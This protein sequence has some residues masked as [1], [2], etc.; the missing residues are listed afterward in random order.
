MPTTSR[1][2]DVRL[3][4]SLNITPEGSLVDL[5]AAV[6]HTAEDRE[7]KNQ[8]SKERPQ[9]TPSET[10]NVGISDMHLKI[11]PESSIREAPRRI[12]R[13]REASREEALA[14]TQQFFAAVD[15]RNR[16][17]ST[18]RSIG[19][20]PEVCGREDIDVPGTSTSVVTTTLVIPDVDPVDTSSPRVILPSGSPS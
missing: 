17:D 7:R 14:S 1:H 11:K 4:P 6:G 19:V 5:L 20:S 12:Q 13:T 15:E 2:E 18:G 8:L 10:A 3:D 16:N 9:E